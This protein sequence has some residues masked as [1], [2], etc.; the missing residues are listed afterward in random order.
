[1]EHMKNT[2][3]IV[4]EWMDEDDAL[5]LASKLGLDSNG[6]LKSI[7]LINITHPSLEE[8]L[9]ETKPRNYIID[10]HVSYIINTSL[11]PCSYEKSSELLGLS[12]IATHE[13]F[14]PLILPILKNFERVVIDAYVYY[15]YCRSHRKN[16]EIC[17]QRMAMKGEP[18]HQ[19]EA[20]QRFPKT[21]LVS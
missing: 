10:E 21:E 17:V 5:L 2:Y 12:N 16:L 15:K 14:S 9:D 1:M 6:E 18:L 13:I 20:I 4:K 7:S 11:N 3:A 19:L 8:A